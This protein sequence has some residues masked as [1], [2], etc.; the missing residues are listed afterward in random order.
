MHINYL[1][2]FSATVSLSEVAVLLM[3]RGT[4]CKQEKKDEL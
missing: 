1:Y 2:V 3:G 4:Q